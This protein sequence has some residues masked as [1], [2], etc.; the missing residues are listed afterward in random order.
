MSILSAFKAILQTRL[1]KMYDL[2]TRWT[3]F[4]NTTELKIS[5]LERNTPQKAL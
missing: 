1:T 2:F 5:K 3:Q 4:G